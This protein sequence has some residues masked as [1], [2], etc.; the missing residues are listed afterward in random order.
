[1]AEEFFK[2]VHKDMYENRPI[3]WPLSSAAK[4]FVAW[5][6]IHRFTAQTLTILLADHLVPT[7]SRI[8]GELSDLRTARDSAEKR[9]AQAAEQRYSSLLRAE[10][11][12]NAF[13]ERVTQCAQRGAPPT[14]AKCPVRE[15]DAPYAPDL[16]DGVMINAAALWPLLDPHW[17]EPKK[18]WKEL[19]SA[20]GRKDYDWAH[21]AMRYWPTRVDAKCQADPSLAVAHGCFWRYHP[22]RAWAW[23]L[24][25]QDE[26]APDFRISEAPYHP[27]GNDLG[28]SGDGP[29]RDAWLRNHPQE[30]LAAVEK[31]AQRRMGRG[32]DRR[33]VATMPILERGLWSVLPAQVWE[34][35]LR[36]A[37]KQR[38]EFRLLSPDEAEARAAYAQAH[39]QRVSDR[40]ALLE[41]LASLPGLFD[42]AAADSDD[43][44]G[45]DA[46]DP[47]AED[48]DEGDDA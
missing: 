36:L 4:T 43:G 13:I 37:E 6:N 10:E 21:L 48:E 47:E 12:L 11:E 7:L 45:E 35:E 40:V 24:R 27:G 44:D 26:I 5:V 28:A 23:E 3:H 8:Q 9:A 39:P 31:E 42:D 22:A 17:K 16:D 14:D 20:S 32:R 1:L 34:M 2:E 19:S 29:H 41:R 25:L 46:A 15:R 38:A 30:A 18:W 33:I